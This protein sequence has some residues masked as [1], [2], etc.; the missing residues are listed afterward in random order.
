MRWTGTEIMDKGEH[1]IL[2]S[3]HQKKHEFGVGFPV[4]KRMKNSVT[5]FIPI[6]PRLRIIRKARRFFNYIIINAHAPVE[7]GR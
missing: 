1:V 2:Y 7:D 5:D 3:G 6:N 4:N